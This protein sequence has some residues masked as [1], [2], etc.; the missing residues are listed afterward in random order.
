M[1]KEGKNHILIP[2]LIAAVAAYFGFKRKSEKLSD[3]ASDLVSKAIKDQTLE[4]V[5]QHNVFRRK[6][7][8]RNRHRRNFSDNYYG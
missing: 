3:I 7:R 8:F 1:R 2:A 6:R 5:Q 4:N